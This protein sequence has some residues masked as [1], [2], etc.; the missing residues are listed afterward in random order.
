MVNYIEKIFQALDRLS[1]DWSE[2]YMLKQET[3]EDI[4]IH[5]WLGNIILGSLSKPFNRNENYDIVRK[6]NVH[7]DAFT[8]LIFLL[9]GETLFSH[10]K[11]II[12]IKE[13]S[14]I[15]FRKLFT[16]LEEIVNNS[17]AVNKYEEIENNF[18]LVLSYLDE[19]SSKVSSQ[20]T[21]EYQIQG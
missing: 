7:F 1:R 12:P 2:I 19:K 13:V 16:I 14:I 21:T 10:K 20:T 18:D 3:K 15:Y 4:G 6:F 8:C 17:K 11:L 5:K 9:C